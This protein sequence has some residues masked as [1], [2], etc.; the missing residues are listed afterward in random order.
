MIAPAW[1][2]PSRATTE[3]H[4]AAYIVDDVGGVHRGGVAADAP[5]GVRPADGDADVPP[6]HVAEERVAPVPDQGVGGESDQPVPQVVL[7][8]VPQQ[9]VVVVE[10]L[11]GGRAE[12]LEVVV[13]TVPTSAQPAG[14]VGEGHLDVVRREPRRRRQRE[15]TVDQRQAGDP[16]GMAV[17]Q[18]QGDE[19]THRHPDDRNPVE[20]ERVEHRRHVVGMTGEPV[21]TLDL[22]AVGT[23][24]Q[25]RRDQGELG[26]LRVQP[27]PEPAV[28]ADPVDREHRFGG[29]TEDLVGEVATGYGHRPDLGRRR[30]G[31][32]VGGR[33]TAARA[34][35]RTGA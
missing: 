7:E 26:R 2:R 34:A 16:F 24:A 4:C 12:V 6:G 31:S 22:D 30:H 35:G 11:A 21:G 25:V 14:P 28:A 8:V 23:T 9:R 29:A 13:E 1:S 33:P 20:A 27:R 5:L 10:Q 15:P 18:G 32:T 3:T 17:S 19:A